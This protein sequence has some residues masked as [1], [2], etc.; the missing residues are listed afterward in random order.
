MSWRQPSAVTRDAAKVRCSTCRRLARVG[1]SRNVM[2]AERSVERPLCFFFLFHFFSFLVNMLQS[3][4]VFGMRR[5]SG[6]NHSLRLGLSR[7]QLSSAIAVLTRALHLH[8]SS[9]RHGDYRSRENKPKSRIDEE[10]AGLA[11][12]FHTHRGRL[13]GAPFCF[14]AY[15]PSR[16]PAQI[17]AFLGLF[18]WE[19]RN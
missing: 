4:F 1:C 14:Y 19:R 2:L 18:R 6:R 3:I 11:W 16:D 10:T 8:F 13:S 15:Q 9:L 7:R 17:W 5:I 12:M